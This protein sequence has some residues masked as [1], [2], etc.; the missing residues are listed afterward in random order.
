[1]KIVAYKSKYSGEI[2]EKRS[3]LIE[4]NKKQKE[5][6]KRESRIIELGRK[7]DEYSS[8]PAQEAKSFTDFILLSKKYLNKILKLSYVT[9]T[10]RLFLAEPNEQFTTGLQI[11]KLELKSVGFFPASDLNH[12]VLKNDRWILTFN[13]EFNKDFLTF[14]GKTHILKRIVGFNAFSDK[15]AVLT[16][17]IGF[18]DKAIRKLQRLEDKSGVIERK[19]NNRYFAFNQYDK[20]LKEKVILL[21]DKQKEIDKLMRELNDIS[22]EITISQT[23][24]WEKIEKEIKNPYQDQIQ[25][26]KKSILIE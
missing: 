1:M 18:I 15:Q 10:G 11:I 9:C 3:D 20:E 5:I 25:T 2:F 16:G 4:H 23:N 22:H 17:S 19:K 12:E 21:T 8:K 26:I 14:G 13:V 7:I 6:I 24:A